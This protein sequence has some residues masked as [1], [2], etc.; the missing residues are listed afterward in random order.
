MLR[1]LQHAVLRNVSPI[2][3]P[4]SIRFFSKLGAQR[5][6]PKSTPCFC[7]HL[8]HHRRQVQRS[9]TKENVGTAINAPLENSSSWKSV[10]ETVTQPFT[11]ERDETFSDTAELSVRYITVHT[12]YDFYVECPDGILFDVC[13][14]DSHPDGV[15]GKDI[16]T[17]VLLPTSPGSHLD[18]LPLMRPLVR[19][20]YR[21]VAVNF[22][23]QKSTIVK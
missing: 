7:P 11:A 17:V 3:V 12:L 23:G 20:G 19:A 21:V 15:G 10:Y 16:K 6:W 5:T 14:V 13:Y 8:L 4:P 2:C 1:L 18:V 22:P 9:H